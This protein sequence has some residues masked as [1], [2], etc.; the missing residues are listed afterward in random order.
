MTVEIRIMV[1]EP[2]DGLLGGQIRQM[3]FDCRSLSAP[4]MGEADLNERLIVID[5]S[6]ERPEREA[7]L[8]AAHAAPQLMPVILAGPAERIH[9]PAIVDELRGGRIDFVIQTP[10][11]PS[12]FH[13]HIKSL[14]RFAN[15]RAEFGRRAAVLARFG[16]AMAP[17]PADATISPHTAALLVAGSGRYFNAIEKS[18]APDMQVFGAL[19]PELAMDRLAE[20][21]ITALV[22]DMSAEPFA[23]A[24]A[25]LRRLRRDARY[26]HLPVILI[27]LADNSDGDDRFYEEGVTDILHPPLEAQALLVS[28][29]P[30]MR[31]ALFREALK[32]AYEEARS[33]PVADA[34]TGLYSRGVL[35]THLQQLIDDGAGFSIALLSVDNMAVINGEFGYAGGDMI[36][37]QIGKAIELLTRG[38]DMAAR[39]SG[40]EFALLM[41]E[42]GEIAAN[43]ALRRILSVLRHTS[44]SPGPGMITVEVEF[45]GGAVEKQQGESPELMLSRAKALYRYPCR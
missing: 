24:I 1:I 10:F 29:L 4:E 12:Q 43:A 13:S 45:G 5:G 15:I 32:T 22:L 44:F 11:T 8:A 36:L 3:G 35:L 31:I 23:D 18:L 40:S 25:F 2:I 39:F 30:L 6:Y 9:Q 17:M 42:T 38:E 26:F 34:L 33:N 16:R 20:G 41:P 14:A 27:P 19:T 28:L 21:G 37:R 7:V